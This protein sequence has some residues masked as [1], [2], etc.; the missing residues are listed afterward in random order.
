M[1]VSKWR[2]IRIPS[3]S[4][5]KDT[6]LSPQCTLLAWP[7]PDCNLRPVL[8][9]GGS[10]RNPYQRLYHHQTSTCHLLISSTLVKFSVIS[11]IDLITPLVLNR[12]EYG[13]RVHGSCAGGDFP[14]AA[15][16]ANYLALAHGAKSS[17][18]GSPGVAPSAGPQLA[19]SSKDVLSVLLHI[20]KC[21]V[22][23]A[24]TVPPQQAAPGINPSISDNGTLN[25]VNGVVTDRHEQV[26][27]PSTTSNRTRP[28]PSRTRAA[29]HPPDTGMRAANSTHTLSSSEPGSQGSRPR[30]KTEGAAKNN[31]G[32]IGSDRIAIMA[33]H[34][35]QSNDDSKSSPSSNLIS[36]STGDRHIISQGLTP[37]IFIHCL[38]SSHHKV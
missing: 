34:V 21:E 1:G 8:L 32:I 18:K 24:S 29:V 13:P 5:F 7:L 22:V 20:A 2:S 3:R 31:T 6:A 26:I 27:N 4:L 17:P 9:L 35:P 10:S 36:R 19:P 23:N 15:S 38:G 37:N 16:P 28:L 12:A 14:Q 30:S 25:G 11:D 33:D